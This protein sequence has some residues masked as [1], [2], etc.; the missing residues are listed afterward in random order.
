MNHI[1]LKRNF[2]E[3]KK[4]EEA[5]IDIGKTW[6]RKIAGWLDWSDLLKYRRVVLLAEASSGKTEE[7]YHRAKDLNAHGKTAFFAR[8]EDLADDGF[9]AALDSSV[10]QMFANWLMKSD[11]EGW[12]FLDSVDEARLNQK[13]LEKALRHF[14]KELN[15]QLERANIYISCRVSDW[16][17]KS[18]WET[19]ERFLPVWKKPT[20]QTVYSEDAALLEPIFRDF[21][22][23]SSNTTSG[24]TKQQIDSLL[25]VQLI[26]LTTEQQ[27]TLAAATGIDHPDEFIQIITQ[28]RLDPFAERPGDLLNLTMYWKEKGHLGSLTQMTK[29]GV[30]HK[31]AEEDSFR[32]D[33]SDLSPDKARHGAELLAAALTLTKSFTLRAPGYPSDLTLSM[34]ALNSADVLKTW[35]DVE[36]NAL[37]R[38]GV[39]SP[40]TYGRVRF[41]H[42]G[43]QEYLT[44]CWFDRLLRG[45]CPKDVIRN[46]IFTE[47]YGLKT[48]VPSL[49]ASAAWLALEH[50][51]IRDE[52]IEREP[53][54]LLRHGDPR[55]LPLAT[56]ERLLISYAR[57]HIAGEISD[58][59]L[60]RQSLWMFA[61]P[62]LADAI[63][64]SWSINER[65]N[66]RIDLLRFIREGAIQACAHLARDVI[67]NEIGSDYLKIAAVEALEACNDVEGLKIAAQWLKRS[68]GYV[69][70]EIGLRFA[71]VLFSRYLTVDEL[72]ELIEHFPPSEG[73]RY[74]FTYYAIE[75]L[76]EACPNTT[77]RERLLLG[78]ADL[79]LA[80][81]FESEHRRISSRYHY[82]AKSLVILARKAIVELGGSEASG[83]LIRSLMAIE[84]ADS[85]NRDDQGTPSLGAIVSENSYIQRDL[86]WADVEETRQN[87]THRDRPTVNIWQVGIFNRPLWQ[88]TSKDL[89]WLFEDLEALPLIDD[90]RIAFSA[91]VAILRN[92]NEIETNLPRLHTLVA[93]EDELRNDLDNYLTPPVEND[94]EREFNIEMQRQRHEET[95]RQRKGKADWIEFRDEINSNPSVLCNPN[96]LEIWDKGIYRLYDLSRWL[97]WKTEEDFKNAVLQWRLLEEGFSRPVAEAYRDGM[98]ALWRITTPERPKRK[99]S[100][101]TTTKHVTILSFS[102]LG[103]EALEDPEWALQLNTTEAERAVQHA[104]LSQQGYPEWIEPLI[105]RHESIALPILHAALQSEWSGRG[106][107][108]STFFDHYSQPNISIPTRIHS[109]LFDVIA[110]KESKSIET[111]N[112]G[113]RILP[114]L[115]I[116][117]KRRRKVL[118]L[119]YRRTRRK[120]AYKNDEHT[121]RYFAMMF[122]IDADRATSELA[123]WLSHTP[124][125]SRGTRAELAIGILFGRD[126]GLSIKSLNKSSVAS[127]EYLIRLAYR[128]VRR[129]DD[130]IHKGVFTPGTRDRA[131]EGRGR[132]LDA[133]ISRP[134]ADAYQTMRTLAADEMFTMSATRFN[135]LAHGKAEQD[136]ELITWTPEEVLNFEQDYIA[137]IKTGDDLL[138]AIINV[139][140]DIQ[141]S[142]S[143]SDATSRSLIQRAKNEDEVQEW[144]GE[145]LNFRSKNRFHVH[146]E[147]QVANRD[148]PDIIISSTSASVEVAVE[149]KHGGMSWSVKDLE[150]ALAK[151]LAKNYL[152]PSTRRH[153]ILIVSYHGR[154]TWRHPNTRVTMEFCEVIEHLQGLA[155]A[156]VSNDFG[157]ICTRVLGI[158]TSQHN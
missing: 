14:A 120:R 71:Q 107:G 17:G 103:I 125:K 78:L 4:D 128:F 127:L 54:V 20:P 81:P 130:K 49:H 58:D 7:F 53:L 11:E 133:L 105:D 135:E 77:I 9:E 42:R 52:I 113:L 137:P 47:R 64:Q 51:D 41:H 16:K 72:L 123:N 124:V 148:K 55:S 98:K 66:F 121:L 69:N 101:V 151:Q 115:Q 33:N 93:E 37:I 150:R 62:D 46:L 56:R 60:D 90:K 140:L 28:N 45:N 153:G 112:Y 27:H 126:D 30:V 110:G 118:S 97:C 70:S 152:K 87:Q 79:S 102:G 40:S 119:A 143:R 106:R 91:I 88:L 84:R 59:S 76:W 5:N 145:Q 10:T 117:D 142:F 44:A 157:Y 100:G 129:E 89:T 68:V 29:H 149:I 92:T 12:F 94:S 132:L 131:E 34:G 32:P 138:R 116:N 85:W 8:I 3:I 104:C 144:L 158:D 108:H 99:K 154:R 75:I 38:R 24:E 114:S 141:S 39:F 48:L 122:L 23:T 22:E 82:L 73:D 50:A 156:L 65:D 6:G 19:V 136:A 18:D 21:H 26:P 96:L 63:C 36:R 67:I 35:K 74:N 61:T 83:G 80:P 1:D 2:V 146:R 95:K 13:S 25:V 134:G 57:L 109:V 111:I 43:T 147:V 155:T 86:F 31:L 15:S 139:L